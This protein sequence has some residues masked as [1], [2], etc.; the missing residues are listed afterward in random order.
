MSTNKKS[1]YKP[2]LLNDNKE[3]DYIDTNI[4][5]MLNDIKSFTYYTVPQYAEGRMDIVSFI[6]YET[7]AFWW[8]ISYYNNI[9]D[10]VEEL[11]TGRILKIPSLQE[12]YKFYNANSRVDQIK[13]R[14][15]SRSL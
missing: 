1:L 14:F 2:V 6:H 9:I 8:L 13:E 7:V 3:L 15:D 10:P 12:Y 11:F 5:D 4:S